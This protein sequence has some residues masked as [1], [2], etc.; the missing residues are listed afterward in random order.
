MRKAEDI[1]NEVNVI[2]FKYI[3]DAVEEA[4]KEAYNDGIRHASAQVYQAYQNGRSLIDK[5]CF[6]DLNSKIVRL[7]KI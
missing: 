6:L 5:S 4:Q 3:I 2:P 7:I 1:L